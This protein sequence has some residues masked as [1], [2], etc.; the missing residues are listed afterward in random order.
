MAGNVEREN[1]YI[2]GCV[3][4]LLAITF[5]SFDHVRFEITPTVTEKKIS[6]V[7]LI[8]SGGERPNRASGNVVLQTESGKSKKFNIVFHRRL[9]KHF[10]DWKERIYYQ[11]KQEEFYKSAM[12]RKKEIKRIRL[13][14]NKNYYTNEKLDAMDYFNGTGFYQKKQDPKQK[15]NIF[16]TRQ[17][18]LLKMHNPI[19][20]NNFL[21]SLNS[22][23][24]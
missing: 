4:L 15:P 5:T 7:L 22:R 12:K 3:N 2:F 10:P 19:L 11:K 17:T 23:S 21:K 14:Y 8:N 13:L 20:R 1:S 9:E 16:D 24:H 6:S 18:F